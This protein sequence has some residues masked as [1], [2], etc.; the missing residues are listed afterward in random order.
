MAGDDSCDRH[1]QLKYDPNTVQQQSAALEPVIR[2]R[3]QLSRR[4][5]I[6]VTDIATTMN[7]SVSNTVGVAD[8]RIVC[9]RG[10]HFDVFLCYQHTSSPQ[11]F[12]S[13]CLINSSTPALLNFAKQY[14]TVVTMENRGS[15]WRAD[16]VGVVLQ[17]ALAK[18]P[19][20]HMMEVFIW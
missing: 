11:V 5:T 18:Q 12:C 15:G 6:F 8:M 19:Y 1:Q 4:D 7:T 20:R 10:C 16:T 17:S 14:H 9:M 3:T 13:S 2:S